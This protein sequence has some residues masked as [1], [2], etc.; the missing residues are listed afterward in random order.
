MPCRPVVKFVFVILASFFSLIGI[1]PRGQT[2]EITNS[3]QFF[4]IQ[5]KATL[6]LNADTNPGAVGGLINGPDGNIWFTGGSANLRYIGRITLDGVI[7]EFPITSA[8]IPY[9]LSVGPDGNIWFSLVPENGARLQT[10][11]GR[12]TLDGVITE[13]EIK[14]G[15]G[16]PTAL[17]T[18]ADGKFW[19]VDRA[20]GVVGSISLTGEVTESVLSM[21]FQ[22]TASSAAITLGADGYVWFA[23]RGK[24]GKVSPAGVVTE[25]TGG[26]TGTS[27]AVGPDRN[28]WMTT[29]QAGVD[30]YIF[31]ISSDGKM[32]KYK[33]SKFARF[34]TPGLDGRL[35]FIVSGYSGLVLRSITT[36]GQL[37]AQEGTTSENPVPY[38]ML[39]G[40]D[41]NLW[42]GQLG[43]VGRM[44][45]SGTAL[46]VGPLFPS[47]RTDSQSYLR[48]HNT[49]TVSGTV[50]VQLRNL[51]TGAVVKNWTSPPI[52]VGANLQISMADI[53]GP[54]GAGAT[55]ADM[56]AASIETEMSGYLQ[57]VLWKPADGTL[58]NLS[59]CNRS[60]TRNAKQLTAVHTSNLDYGYPSKIIIHNPRNAP[61]S[62][63]LT[64][65]D[66]RNG[67]Q[68]WTYNA[69]V[70]AA[71]SS[72]EVNVSDMERAVGLFPLADVFH[73]VV[74]VQG[75]FSGYLQHLVTNKAAGVVTDMTQNCYLGPSGAGDEAAKFVSIPNQ[76]TS[77][78]FDITAGG[79]GAIWVTDQGNNRVLRVDAS[80]AATPFAIPTGN[81][82]P[83]GIAAGPNQSIWFT[84]YS[85]NKIGRIQNDVVSEFS[86]PTQT[87]R[88]IDIVAGGDGA[89]WFAENAGNKIG[90]IQPSGVI[91]EFTIPTAF[92]APTDMAAASDGSVWFA[93][94]RMRKLARVTS[95]GAI[96]EYPL[97]TFNEP[98]GLMEGADQF[99]WYRSGNSNVARMNTAGEVSYIYGTRAIG[100]S[101]KGIARADKNSVWFSSGSQL[102]R[103]TSRGA[104][105]AYN[106]PD[107]TT[108][109][110]IRDIAM[111]PDG[112]LWFTMT[113][114]SRLGM[115]PLRPNVLAAGAIY[116]S[117]DTQSQSYLR[118]Y[119]TS[120][121]PG[122]ARVTLKESAS[123]RNLG[124]WT[125]PV[126]AS[127]TMRQ[128]HIADVEQAVAA[129]ADV[130]KYS[131][132]LDTDFEGTF[133]HVLW[134]P[135]DGTLTNLSSCDYDVMT[136]PRDLTGVHTSLLAS[137]YPSAIAINNTGSAAAS[138]AIRIYAS[139][140]GQ[141][142][143][144]YQTLS[145]AA[146][147]G[148]VV[149]MADIESA[150]GIV[151]ANDNYHY[152]L[153][154]DGAFH[155]YLQHLVDNRR[156][157]VVT[158]MSS[159]CRLRYVAGG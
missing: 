103:L 13:I 10:K 42:V 72:V 109:S 96:Q 28:L 106:G 57:H 77:G 37:S 92:S 9:G 101:S 69:G 14:N 97:P 78:L 76:A 127:G 114:P 86:I 159:F 46:R 90:R 153:K 82:S 44:R 71:N 24:V 48:F 130:K 146:G 131:I 35:W 98:L 41:G 135:A 129:V 93:Q 152:I 75:V 6:G 56:Y 113:T 141:L 16:R 108:F 39:L 110:Y 45:M 25:Y 38:S 85:A 49:G 19:F 18:G 80:G 87:S 43:R 68:L 122:Y 21:E 150:V 53:E 151:P 66:A 63:Q 112:N 105:T 40:A 147:G 29:T 79:D 15:A 144:V 132:T 100:T 148:M 128:F 81:A 17:V 31:R 22:E 124:V 36:D 136:N 47:V 154:V 8:N 62:P 116:P 51:N 158:D 157:G 84:E 117:A 95:D 133:Q 73:Y 55:A 91:S 123:G 27:I 139:E 155:G 54:G 149:A 33:I 2:Q 26:E 64:V 126:I 104:M 23:G 52:A 120:Q 89:M 58:T 94:P 142:K 70:V 59:T 99:M 7:T 30:G 118:F 156:A 83:A 11:L 145:L 121:K 12:I 3:Y 125:S 74:S 111:G 107:S 1:S 88:P 140:S 5:P 119:N 32:T 50:S 134:K 137:Q 20:I 143:G 4:P 34:I 61:I 138:T 67:V 102:I 60:V 115:L 65:S